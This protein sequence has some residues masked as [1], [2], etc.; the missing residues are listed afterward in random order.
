M[1]SS[2]GGGSGGSHSSGPSP[3]RP[4]TRTTTTAAAAAAASPPLPPP[5]LP[6]PLAPPP[7]H[8]TVRFSAS[9]PDLHLDIP[10]PART[11]VAALKHLIR[12]R[13]APGT[14]ARRLRFIHGGR[15]LADGAVLGAVLRAPPPPPPGDL[16]AAAAATP[17][18]HGKGKAREGAGPPPA[19]VYVN[20]SIGDVLSPAELEAEAAAAAAAVPSASPEPTKGAGGG[21]G[22]EGAGGAPRVQGA[23]AVPRGFDR[24]LGAG[25]TVAEVNAL[26]LQFTS[27]HAARHTPDTM[28]SSEE[29]RG[30]EDAW[31]DSNGAAGGGG[32]SFASGGAGG[33][34]G[35][36]AADEEYGIIGGLLDVLVYGMTI[37]FVWPL[38]S[39]GW[40]LLEEGLWSRKWQFFVIAGVVF[41]L[42]LGT[43]KGIA[44][45]R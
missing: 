26:R 19:R 12:G 11:T 40:L 36:G 14:A 7:L 13:L 42:L 43:I 37:G 10:R 32:M 18:P 45:D 8:L 9:L 27:I 20:C 24:L 35:E 30:L 15:I 2:S 6:L 38:G 4:L 29:L 22:G 34:G 25:F 16:A 1:S 28:P 17:D 33:A 3:T 5:R 21:S 44:G 39:I 23:A 41:S 31:L